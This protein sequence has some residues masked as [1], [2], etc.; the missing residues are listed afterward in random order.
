VA[1][2]V[3]LVVLHEPLR[4]SQWIAVLCVVVASA[5]ATRGGLPEV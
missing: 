1:A 3:G 2:L 5:G 4:A